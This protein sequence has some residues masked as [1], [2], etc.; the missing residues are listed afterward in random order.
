MYLALFYSTYDRY[1][2]E[3]Y[4][5]DIVYHKI[6]GKTMTRVNFVSTINKMGDKRIII[7]PKDYHPD[8]DKLNPKQVK[9]TIDDEI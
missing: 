5:G 8:L 7:I 2:N 3:Y 9:V 1:D 4:N 6:T